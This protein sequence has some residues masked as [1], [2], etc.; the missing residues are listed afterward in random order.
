MADD[1]VM[2]G[3]VVGEST[4]QEFR[5]AV[6]TGRVHVQDLVAVDAQLEEVDG[7]STAICIWAKLEAIEHINPLFPRE[8]E[9]EL[10]D[11]Q[12]NPID[13]VI[14]LSREMIIALCRVLGYEEKGDDSISIEAKHSSP[15]S[16]CNSR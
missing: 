16:A 7:K 8:S 5:M 3:T 1:E 11:L 2:V 12:V 14:S 10:A 6:A 15:G 4:T 9:Q 13:T